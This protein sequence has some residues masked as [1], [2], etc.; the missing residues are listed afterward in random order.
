MR[1]SS[2]IRGRPKARRSPTVRVRH[3]RFPRVE[4]AIRAGWAAIGWG[5]FMAPGPPGR[6]LAPTGGG[7]AAT[8]GTSRQAPCPTS[9][10]REV[11]R[12]GRQRDRQRDARQ[13]AVPSIQSSLGGVRKNGCRFVANA[14]ADPQLSGVC[15]TA[16]AVGGWGASRQTTIRTYLFRTDTTSDREITYRN[17]RQHH[18]R[19][20]PHCCHCAVE[21]V[22]SVVIRSQR[23][24]IA[25]RIRC[26]SFPS[27]VETVC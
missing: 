18:G 5:A 9:L 19:L 2:E 8:R 7:C 26:L 25:P 16:M 23:L 12:S 6:S 13:R 15:R 4:R 10:H 14:L 17:N 22:V 20:L 11:I 3:R 1:R 27:G 21:L 24:G